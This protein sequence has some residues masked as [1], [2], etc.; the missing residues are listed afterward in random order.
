MLRYLHIQTAPL[1]VEYARQ[2]LHSS[3]YRMIP[4]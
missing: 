2:M 3:D 4:N 1:M